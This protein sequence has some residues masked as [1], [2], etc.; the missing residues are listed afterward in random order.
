LPSFPLIVRCVI[1]IAIPFLAGDRVI[2]PKA[3]D[4]EALDV[5]GVLHPTGSARRPR[6]VATAVP[7]F[8]IPMSSAAAGA[9]ES[10]RVG[11]LAAGRSRPSRGRASWH[12]EVI[13]SSPPSVSTVNRS[14]DSAA[15]HLH[16]LAES[17]TWAVAARSAPTV[18]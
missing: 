3:V 11:S 16:Q 15:G 13:E 9:R 6:T 1:N 4:D 5:G 17:Y 7:S 8:A 14:C 18:A 10:R 12:P 2:A